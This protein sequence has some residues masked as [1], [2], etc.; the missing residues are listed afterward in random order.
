[1][2]SLSFN[3]FWNVFP[4]NYGPLLETNVVG[5]PILLNMFVSCWITI[6]VVV[7]LRGTASGHLVARSI[8]V[9]RYL[10]PPLAVGNGPTRLLQPSQ[11]VP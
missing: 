9:R 4:T 11:M 8:Q 10:N 1:M 3:H 6:L 2:I 5:K 7:V